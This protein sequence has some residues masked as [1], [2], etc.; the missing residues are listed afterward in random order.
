M[1][2]ENT[3]FV[4]GAG[5]SVPYEF[6]TAKML[7]TAICDRVLA[8][9][10]LTDVQ[11]HTGI[12]PEIYVEMAR[13][14]RISRAPSID[15]WLGDRE[16]YIQAGK[17]CI[18]REIIEKENLMRLE[19]LN[20]PERW[21]ADLFHTY[22]RPH[23]SGGYK[24][25][26]QNSV[27]FITF[28]YDRSLEQALLLLLQHNYGLNE[29]AA[30]DLVNQVNILHVY[31]QLG[32]LPWQPKDRAK[33]ER[34]YKSVA[35]WGLAKEHSTDIKVL[36]EADSASDIFRTAQKWLGRAD[37]ICFLGFGY[38]PE[39][40]ARLRPEQITANVSGSCFHLDL[41]W[42]EY[43]ERNDN[44]PFGKR[45]IMGDWTEDALGYLKARVR[46]E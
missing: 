24:A 44:N 6:P 11:I 21:Y 14:L 37:K 27:Y 29:P 40:L 13:E 5:A 41:R 45:I 39:N 22:L 19:G 18:A 1:F 32:R 36:S 31:G 34:P 42:K 33:T 26:P 4:L 35:D 16:E 2:K 23:R 17:I 12:S 30:A 7:T 3:V 28:N 9:G 20:E 25:F 46:P 38:H 15:L 10:Y 8:T 43:L